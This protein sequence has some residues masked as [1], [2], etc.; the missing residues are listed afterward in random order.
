MSKERSVIVKQEKGSDVVETVIV[1]VKASRDI[2]KDALVWTLTHVAQPG[3]CITLIVVMPSLI[4]GRKLWGL[5]RFTGDC[6]SRHW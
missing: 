1:A 2:S 4:S 5:P 3:H 6:A